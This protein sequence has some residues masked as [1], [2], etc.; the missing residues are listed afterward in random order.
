M[1][2]IDKI[3]FNEQGLIPAIVQDSETNEVLMMAYMNKIAL[4]ETFKTG[5]TH[6]YSRSRKSQWKKG[7]SSGHL[8]AVK[9]ILIDCD[10]DTILIKAEQTGGACHMGYKTCFFRKINGNLE[11]LE[12]VKEKVFDPD[13]VYE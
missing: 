2:I 9:E 13:K 10:L 8:Q 5:F 4:E 12:I 1:S 6:F 11:E 7:E 3:K